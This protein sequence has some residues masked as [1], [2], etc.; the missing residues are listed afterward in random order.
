LLCN[1]RR[2]VT[3]IA[4]A[5][6]VAV[7][8]RAVDVRAW[9]ADITDRIGVLVVLILVRFA[10]AVIDVVGDRVGVEV[11]WRSVN[12]TTVEHR[13]DHRTIWL[14]RK[15]SGFQTDVL[16][17]PELTGTDVVARSARTNR[18]AVAARQHPDDEYRA[19]ASV[20][21]NDR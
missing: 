7:A 2:W 15:L 11:A 6:A 8:V 12:R 16:D 19:H 5:I 13:V 4:D 17:A 18:R 9:I 21:I 3:R 10:G 1:R 20:R 14:G